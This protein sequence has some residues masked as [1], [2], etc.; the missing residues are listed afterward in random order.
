MHIYTSICIYVC[1]CI[2]IYKYAYYIYHVCIYILINT[3]YLPKTM[4]VGLLVIP[5]ISYRQV[6]HMLH[7][8]P[9]SNVAYSNIQQKN[10]FSIK[11]KFGHN[12]SNCR[13]HAFYLFTILHTF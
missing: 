4:K 10:D 6:W 3:R 5:Y 11:H 7:K 9:Y 2:N 13:K 1:I 12:Q 8:Y